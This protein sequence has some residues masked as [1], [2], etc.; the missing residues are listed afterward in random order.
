MS[1]TKQS[2]RLIVR[3]FVKAPPPPLRKRVGMLSVWLVSRI[4]FTVIVNLTAVGGY[5]AF[6]WYQART[7]PDVA[8]MSTE[9]R[10]ALAEALFSY[11]PDDMEQEGKKRKG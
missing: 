10:N 11:G 9:Q 5:Q 7:I 1:E 3:R 4:F 8:A 6:Q 2:K